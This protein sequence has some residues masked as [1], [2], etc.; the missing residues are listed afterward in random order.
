MFE[1]ALAERDPA[2]RK[3]GGV[4]YTPPWLA[5]VLVDQSL[6]HW[7]AAG[8]AELGERDGPHR[9]AA[10][11]RY[12]ARVEAL[13]VLDPAC[14]GGALLAEALR[15]LVDER[16]WIADELARAT[17]CPPAFDRARTLAAILSANIYGLD[18]D[19]DAVDITRLALWLD[20]ETRAEP[21]SAFV[22]H[23]AC[24]DALAGLPPGWPPGFD[25]IVANPP[26]VR[27]QALE[28][29]GVDLY[30]RFIARGL[31]LLEGEG[32]MG[33]IAPSVW[34][35]AAY[36]RALRERVCETR[37]LDRWIDFGSH[38]LFAGAT[39]Y[40]AIQLF[41]GAAVERIRYLDG[42]RGPSELEPIDWD[43]AS[44]IPYAAVPGGAPWVLASAPE[45]ALLDRLASTSASLA[46]VSAQIAVGVQTSAD[47]VFHLVRLGP[48]RYRKRR[49]GAEVIE[50]EDE[51][52]RPLLVGGAVARYEAPRAEVYILFPYALAH[53]RARV[54][55]PAELGREFPRA[56]AYLGSCEPELR[57]RE[58]G[59]FDDPRWYRFGRS[60]NIARQERAKLCVAQTVPHLRV[61][62][63]RAGGHVLHNVR[64][65]GVLVDSPE[66][67]W[68][69]LG[70]LNGPVCDYVFRRV[71]KPKAGGFFEANKQYIAGLP[72]PRTT[73]AQRGEVATWAEQLQARWTERRELIAAGHGPQQLAALDA[74]I[75]TRERA[76]DERLYALHDLP[77]ALVDAIERDRVFRP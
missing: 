35:R 11:R 27:R 69:V 43:Q 57:A 51:L 75:A 25:C 59:R 31:E 65:N 76:L 63:D 4:Y 41:A 66:T 55:S 53:G 19:V 22:A 54:L 30:V 48:G 28:A 10:L 38:Q 44:E 39:T 14:G 68:F 29:G 62:F 13:T 3:R 6:G 24:A 45:R 23:I 2:R 61:C 77:A 26:Y 15:V 70:V 16:R 47:A 34:L 1:R 52:M 42:S 33:Y 36:G 50:I 12:A 67:G 56:W 72:I 7:L 74:E 9:A 5:R 60:Q 58:R 73:A 71:A 17:G 49:G 46:E 37:R 40:T 18:I 32:V 21:P 8:R 64:V 20:A